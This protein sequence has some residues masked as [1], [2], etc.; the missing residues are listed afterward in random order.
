MSPYGYSTPEDVAQRSASILDKTDWR[1]TIHHALENCVKSE[2]IYPNFI[3]QVRKLISV[4][5]AP[6]PGFNAKKIILVEVKKYEDQYSEYW[7]N[8]ISEHATS[9]RREKRKKRQEIEMQLHYEIYIYVRDLLAERR[10]LLYGVRQT[11]GGH[12]APDPDE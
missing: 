2:G 3:R 8:W 1:K 9:R 12:Q 6:Y 5:A 10:I 11:P 4:V 7:D